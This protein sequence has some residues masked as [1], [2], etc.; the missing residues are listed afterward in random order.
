MYKSNNKIAITTGDVNG[1]GAEITIKA[2][3]YFAD[4]CPDFSNENV[5][6]ISNKK[7]L[8]FY[9]KLKN[10]YELIEI[11][12]DEKDIQPGKI[13]AES[14][15]FGYKALVKACEMAKNKEI[16]AIVTAPLSKIGM[17]MAGHIFNGQTEVLQNFLAKENQRADMLFIAR[18]FRVLLLTR[19]VALKEITITQAQVIEQIQ[20]LDKFF[21]S[22]LNI[23]A[24]KFALCAFNP[25]AGE[26]GIL[27]KEEIEILQP[28]IKTL[29]EMGIDVTEPLPADTLFI[30]ASDAYLK[31]KKNPFDCYIANYHDQGLIP[32]KTVASDKTVNMT[33]GL[34]VIRTSPSHGTAFDIA[35]KSLASEVS[36]I[37]AINAA[38]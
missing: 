11:D 7:V 35:G 15:D 27:G 24:P 25:H 18:D 1:I 29:K 36:M 9:G 2:L 37:E 3:N 6:I 16:N 28:A 34:D 4:N 38:L 32:I 30:K 23:S 31:N 10:N 14:G 20:N 26:G 8:D 21:K 5:V 17:H 33:I 19:H 12:F 22:K 13:T